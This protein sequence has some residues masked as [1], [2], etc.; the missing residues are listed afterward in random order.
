[1]LSSIT[2]WLAAAFTAQA[3]EGELA[4]LRAQ[5]E[6]PLVV[7]GELVNPNEV[8]RF[9]VYNVG[10]PFLAAFERTSL[11]K[12]YTGEAVD[13][14]APGTSREFERLEAQF[15]KHYEER[16]L[17][18]AI[19]LEFGSRSTANFALAA[20]SQFEAYFLP[21]NPEHWPQVS[22]DALAAEADG[23]V[24]EEARRDYKEWLASGGTRGSG[25]EVWRSYLRETVELAIRERVSVETWK[26]GLPPEVVMR[27][28]GE[29]G[30]P[31]EE[32]SLRDAFEQVLPALDSELI[33]RERRWVTALTAARQK[34]REDGLLL[35]KPDADEAYDEFQ[36]PLGCF[37]SP[38]SIA[39]YT[40]YFPSL[41][42]HRAY[43]DLA[44]SYDQ[45]FEADDR[46]LDHDQLP[47]RALDHLNVVNR[48]KGLARVI[49][50]VV[51]V[52]A[53][54]NHS[55][56]ITAKGWK[57]ALET[58]SDAARDLETR[59]SASYA[60]DQT[61]AGVAAVKSRKVRSLWERVAGEYSNGTHP[62][63]FSSPPRSGRSSSRCYSE[64]WPS[65]GVTYHDA[66]SQLFSSH[67]SELLSVES[68]TDRV[69]SEQEAGSVSPPLRTPEGYAV[70]WLIGRK[71]PTNP[72]RLSED[73]H[74][75]LLRD[76]ASRLEFSEYWRNALRDALER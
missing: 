23:Q 9:L 20:L 14:E 10:A 53:R 60:L 46:E 4:T 47:L 31:R 57:S 64:S 65:R 1:M 17:E 62:P 44:Q 29:S 35:S 75:R 24:L 16:L 22:I 51:H 59:L 43:F 37:F 2:L 42:H 61:E 74:R 12:C 8:K 45:V 11:V 33:A 56:H 21:L 6:A 73:R 30:A 15:L 54:D 58:A 71:E 34:L 48:R 19:R 41:D 76:E 39:L 5:V 72:L 68:I 67:Y 63:S 32:L 26:D 69:F 40:D 28:T 7:N 50:K 52:S 27:V 66:R 36:R 70:V 38:E 13:F 55:G 3:T 18:P 25:G 49:A